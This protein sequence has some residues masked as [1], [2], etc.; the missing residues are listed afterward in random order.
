MEFLSQANNDPT[1]VAVEPCGA[2]ALLRKL[3]VRIVGKA[4]FLG[5][6]DLDYPTVVNRDFDRAIPQFGNYPRNP[7]VDR[8]PFER[9]TGV[10]LPDLTFRRC[11]AH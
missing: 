1:Y 10:R 8:T 7:L 9:G 11:R 3:T 2:A 4:N 6:F 5:S